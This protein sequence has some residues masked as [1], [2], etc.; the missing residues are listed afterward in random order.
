MIGDFNA[1]LHRDR[2]G[3]ESVL[4]P[5]GESPYRNDNGERLVSFCCTNGVCLGNTFFKHKL[6]HKKTWTSPDGATQ[7]E[8]DYICIS[9]RWKTSLLDVRV[10]RG[11]DVGSDH[12]L[13]IAKVRLKLKRRII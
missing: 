10:Y 2:Q 1:Q 12:H 3:Y 13:I 4:G 6:I 7:K 11:A 5:Y 8:L 9:N